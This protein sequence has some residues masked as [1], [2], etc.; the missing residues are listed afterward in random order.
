MS[1]KNNNRESSPDVNFITAIFQKKS[2]NTGPSVSTKS[3]VLKK[4]TIFEM[5][6]HFAVVN[7]FN[8]FL[9]IPIFSKKEKNSKFAIRYHSS[10]IQNGVYF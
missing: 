4:E 3:K 8:N 6:T 1:Y 2:I 5:A 7:S 9:V 10:E